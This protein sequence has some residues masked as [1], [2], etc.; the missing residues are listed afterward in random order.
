MSR[1]SL[2]VL[3][4]LVEY[5]VLDGGDSLPCR[6]CHSL[7][8]RIEPSVDLE[9][10]DDKKKQKMEPKPTYDSSLTG[11]DSRTGLRFSCSCC[12]PR[13]GAPPFP[14]QLAGLGAR[15]SLNPEAGMCLNGNDLD[16]ALRQS[17]P[18]FPGLSETTAVLKGAS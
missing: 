1:T 15:D 8:F 11:T 2:V 18:V 16:S 9:T 4:G 7:S 17:R 3:Y 6:I 5:E 13:V 10:N 14:V 12:F